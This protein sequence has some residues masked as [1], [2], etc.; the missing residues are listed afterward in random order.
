MCKKITW[1]PENSSA[2]VPPTWKMLSLA[3]VYSNFILV[4]LRTLSKSL[5]LSGS[6]VVKAALQFKVWVRSDQGAKIPMSHQDKLDI[7]K[8]KKDF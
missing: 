2:L 1:I 5:G 3:S 7:N 6:L 8:F 4:T